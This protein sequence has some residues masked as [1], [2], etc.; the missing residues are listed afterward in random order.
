VRRRVAGVESEVAELYEIGGEPVALLTAHAEGRVLVVER[1]R[2]T[3]DQRER[4]LVGFLLDR[5][6]RD[7][8]RR[9]CLAV[10]FGDRLL[11]RADAGV[12]ESAGVIALHDGQGVKF[13][14]SDSARDTA[15]LL[16]VAE[17]VASVSPVLAPAVQNLRAASAQ[18]VSSR[19]QLFLE[20]ALFPSVRSDVPLPCWIV[21]IRP[22][23]AMELFD[24]R[25]RQSMLFPP[26]GLH[27][28]AFRNVYYSR[29]ATAWRW[30]ARILWYVSGDAK[31]PASKAIRAASVLETAHRATAR[32]LSR[33]QQLGVYDRA[34]LETMASG[35][36][37]LIWCLR[38]S[39]TRTF[40]TP[41]SYGWLMEALREEGVAHANL[42]GPTEIPHALFLRIFNEGGHAAG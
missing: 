19:E 24:D 11:T 35:E 3:R 6:V 18:A 9:G 38:F 15:A 33:Y 17:Q 16:E 31:Q 13:V 1:L 34:Q 21:P 39:C 20:R 23:Y 5:V 29:A 4:A 36:D 10:L 22:N 37:G 40:D 26:E 12:L 2:W 8:L 30:P 27:S 28:L 41:I 42:V 7:A 14:V 32:Q 25:M